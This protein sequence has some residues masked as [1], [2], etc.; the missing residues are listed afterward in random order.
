MMVGLSGPT[1][2]S[3]N[4]LRRIISEM[5]LTLPNDKP[6]RNQPLT[7]YIMNEYRRHQ[8][9][10]KQHCKAGQE[11]EHLSNTYATYL[12]SQRLWNAINK[13]YHATGEK[14]VKETASIVG[15]KLPHDP[16]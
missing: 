9:T 11:M 12:T 7:K 8:I 5:R 10:T 14:S 6:V 16:K 4:S 15:F 3:L 13:E 1:R 2:G